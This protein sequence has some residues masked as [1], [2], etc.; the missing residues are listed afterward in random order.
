MGKLKH[1]VSLAAEIW[2]GTVSLAVPLVHI[3]I[4][5]NDT[6]VSTGF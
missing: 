3:S 4:P 6:D 2:F 1:P 5:E